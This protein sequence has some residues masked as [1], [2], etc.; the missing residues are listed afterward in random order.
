MGGV[1][2]RSS[3]M[4]SVHRRDHLHI[5]LVGLRL[6]LMSRLGN[7][8]IYPY[9]YTCTYTLYMYMNIHVHVRKHTLYMYNVHVYLQTNVNV[10]ICIHVHVQVYYHIFINVPA[11]FKQILFNPFSTSN[12]SVVPFTADTSCEPYEQHY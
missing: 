11:C 2:W 3:L 10:W 9:N 12:V 1:I 5:I 6:K 7:Q 8:T 4:S